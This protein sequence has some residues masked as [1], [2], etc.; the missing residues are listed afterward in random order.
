M[1]CLRVQRFS[2]VA[3]L[4]NSLFV[5]CLKLSFIVT[6]I[7]IRRVSYSIALFVAFAKKVMS[8]YLFVCGFVYEYDYPES[9]A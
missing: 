7:L 2:L 4:C 9:C 6:F 1:S 8:L 5:I 3:L